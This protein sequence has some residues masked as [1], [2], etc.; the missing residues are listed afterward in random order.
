MDF[1]DGWSS[2][3]PILKYLA[4]RNKITRILETGLGKYS[5]SLFLNKE[6]FPDLI[7]LISIEDSKDWIDQT[8]KGD[9][10][11][12]ILAEKDKVFEEVKKLD[13]SG[14]DLIFI[15]DSKSEN[16]RSSTIREVAK[17]NPNCFVVIHDYHREKYQ[18][19][20]EGFKFRLKIDN[21]EIP[22][23]PKS[24]VS[25]GLMS[26]KINVKELKDEDNIFKKEK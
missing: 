18:K 10:Q 3:T 1:I 13:L 12:I 21:Y 5:T 16:A 15:D 22:G 24:K 23:L 19:A 6:V 26:N 7:E 4:E 17:K 14:F 25:T 11:T 20:S 9:N 2:H 8:E